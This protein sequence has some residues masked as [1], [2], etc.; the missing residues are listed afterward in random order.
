MPA[1]LPLEAVPRIDQHDGG[2]GVAGA[3]RHVARVLVVAGAVDQHEAALVRIEVAPGDVDGDALLA[4]GDEAVEQEAIVE[5]VRMARGTCARGVPVSRSI[6]GQIG[7][8]PTIDG[9]SASTCRRRP[10]RR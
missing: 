6:V 5:L 4:L 1:R 7:G 9:R 10:S 2:I 8:S 3:A